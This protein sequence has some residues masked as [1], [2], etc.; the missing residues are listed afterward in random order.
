M[1]AF[2][3]AHEV[4]LAAAGVAVID[5]IFA[6]NPALQSNG[7]LHWIFTELG[8]LAGNGSASVTPAVK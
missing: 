1:L 8:T 7:I 5:L 4:I 2:I 6:I 3:Q